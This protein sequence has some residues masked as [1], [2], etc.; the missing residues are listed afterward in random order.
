MSKTDTEKLKERLSLSNKNIWESIDDEK[1]KKVD[2]FC[3][4]YKE[5]LDKCKTERES[6]NYIEIMLRKNGFI[7]IE[8][9]KSENKIKKGL[10]LY[11][12]NR[13]KSLIA[14]VIGDE[15]LLQGINMTGAHLDAPGI[16]LKHN[17]LYENS[18]IAFLKTH[19][20]GGIKK[21]QWVTVPLSMHGVIVKQNG[22]TIELSLGEK[23]NEPVFTIADLLPHLAQDQM[24]KK[25][26]EG[27][28]GEDLNI[29]FGTIP[30]NDNKIEEKVK[31]NI[32][33]MLNKEYGI[34]EEDFISSDIRF[35]PIQKAC[36]VG[37]D[38]SM[39]GAYG[40]D[41]RSCS[42]TA[43]KALINSSNLKKTAICYLSDREEI[44][45][46][47]NTGAQ[48][49]MLENFISR[50]SLLYNND[51]TYSITRKCIEKSVMLSAD[52]NAAY[53]PTFPDVQEIRNASQLGKG[54]IIQKFTGSRGKADGSEASAELVASLRKIFNENNIIWQASELGKVDKGGG[55][56]IAQYVANL[57]V[58]VIDVGICLLS[59]HSP[60]EISSKADIYSS[61]KAFKM[62]YKYMDS[63]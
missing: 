6:V 48:S 23:E 41:D 43:I 21:Y 40:Q 19:Y 20:Y 54:V 38:R 37:F 27:I 24:G 22:D 25:M 11:S 31:L 39:I 36:D 4:E 63:I 17:P 29:L 46:M 1:R 50:L 44:G 56:T 10:K 2:E 55:G 9:I 53:D 30:F 15:D 28:T 12:V 58:D 49:T 13:N 45:S 57:G 35:V 34:V 42:Y 18:E 47:G 61:Y 3:E 62:F 60:F 59:M 14:A 32:L 52:V 5:F 7:K 26:S 8:E 16:D 51:D 33:D